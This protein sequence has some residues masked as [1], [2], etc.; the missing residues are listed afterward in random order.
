M[1]HT[2]IIASTQLPA[3]DAESQ[4]AIQAFYDE[5]GRISVIFRIAG[6]IA[7]GCAMLSQLV[8]AARRNPLPDLVG[9][10]DVVR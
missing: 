2:M 3:A 5:H 10:P 6:A 9:R 1:D 4:D 7:R 8:S